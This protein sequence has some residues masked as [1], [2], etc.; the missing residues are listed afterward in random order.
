MKLALSLLASMGFLSANTS[1]AFAAAN[2]VG[3]VKFPET[4]ARGTLP[5]VH[6][7][8]SG[9]LDSIELGKSWRCSGVSAL[10]GVHNATGGTKEIM[11]FADF[12]RFIQNTNLTADEE[13]NSPWL[14]KPYSPHASKNAFV[15]NTQ[16]EWRFNR[17]FK[18]PFTGYEALRMADGRLV[19]ERSA[20]V[21]EVM[22]M[23]K[24]WNQLN[25][26]FAIT[27]LHPS[28]A[29]GNQGL[30]AYEYSVCEEFSEAI[31]TME[32]ATARIPTTPSLPV[33]FTNEVVNDMGR[34]F[35]EGTVPTQDDLKEGDTWN[36][37][38]SWAINQLSLTTAET[39][40]MRFKWKGSS[41]VENVL[42]FGDERNVVSQT[43]EYGHNRASGRKELA[44]KPKRIFQ[45]D[46]KQNLVNA[47]KGTY[48]D[49]YEAIRKVSNV[50]PNNE[51][52]LIIERSMSQKD[53]DRYSKAFQD[54]LQDESF[55]LTGPASVIDPS[56]IAWHY[57]VC[58]K[59]ERTDGQT[60]RPVIL[61][62]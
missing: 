40:G 41:K 60:L 50:G 42:K 5:T 10:W 33:E 61:N 25:P 4:F 11:R 27:T 3:I 46:Y 29:Y 56:R 17:G 52:Y 51:Q 54:L 47:Q 37:Q 7:E 12:Y 23:V 57:V 44:W 30:V 21:T 38:P 1:T 19:I 2:D 58:G 62:Q 48:I 36:C 13:K 28:I 59:T 14:A 32:P 35:A 24:E 49:T 55:K 39:P 45:V 15:R 6:K 53:L 43:Y 26:S 20:S 9:R 16:M 31:P 22:P 8:G 34:D 18:Q